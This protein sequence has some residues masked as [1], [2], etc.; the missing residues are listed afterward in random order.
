MI[1][2]GNRYYIIRHAAVKINFFLIIVS[3]NLLL[4]CLRHA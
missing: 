4:S 2:S 3:C 1:I